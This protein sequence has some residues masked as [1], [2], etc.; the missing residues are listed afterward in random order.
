MSAALS[1]ARR[2]PYQL[3]AEEWACPV[4]VAP[5][6]PKRHPIH[7]K[8]SFQAL[9]LA[10]ALAL[11]LLA[12]FKEK[13]GSLFIAPGEDFPLEAYRTGAAAPPLPGGA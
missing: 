8:R 7:G 9:C 5:L 1:E 6:F 10:S 2:L 3:G 13:G 11:D 4:A 12:G